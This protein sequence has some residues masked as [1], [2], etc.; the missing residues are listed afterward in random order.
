MSRKMP[1]R[2][3][4]QQP[5][6]AQRHSVCL[7]ALILVPVFKHFHHENVCRESQI[8]AVRAMKVP[9]CVSVMEAL[10]KKHKEELEKAQRLC[11][12]ALD[13]HTLKAQQQ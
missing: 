2:H 5:R 4:F 8:A 11:G 3:P 9:V 7:F 13:S 12:G 1:P 10:R 6:C